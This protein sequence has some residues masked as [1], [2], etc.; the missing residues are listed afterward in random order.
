MPLPGDLDGSLKGEGHSERI[1][2]TIVPTGV[3]TVHRVRY[4]FAVPYC[5]GKRV[6]DVAC[7]AGYGSDL[8]AGVARRVTGLDVDSAPPC[9][10]E[11]HY[12]Q[13]GLWFTVGDAGR[14]AF[15]GRKLRRRGF[16]RDHRTPGGDPAV[17]WRSPPCPCARR[18][19]PRLDTSGETDDATA[20]ESSPRCRVFRGGFRG[21]PAG[22]IQGS[23]KLTGRAR[24]Q[25]RAHY[26][27]QKLDVLHLRRFVP[28]R[29]RHAV[30]S[31]LGTTPFEEMQP[32]DQMIVKG[33]PAQAEYI[34]A[35]CR[36]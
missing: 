35:V 27:L 26:W 29:L 18:R 23:L 19:L 6:L 5:R 15:W 25:S 7:G 13:E 31:K 9:T 11:R 22:A 2:P 3:L 32:R 8:L 10:R 4:E 24:V 36:I 1:D 30:D 17:P 14:L 34:V 20:E 33:N 12:R 16:L 21:A 28:S